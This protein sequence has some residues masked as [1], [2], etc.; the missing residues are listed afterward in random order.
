[1]LR[2]YIIAYKKAMENKDEK[3]MKRIEKDLSQ[4]GMDRYT[5]RMLVKETL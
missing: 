4:L 5:L 1:M 2:D 3:E